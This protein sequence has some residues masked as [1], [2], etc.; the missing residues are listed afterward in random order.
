M[1]AQLEILLLDP[2]AAK[3]LDAAG[4]EE[5]EPAA[6]QKASNVVPIGKGK[7]RARRQPRLPENIPV[8]SQQPRSS[9]TRSSSI[10]NSSAKL[11]S[12]PAS[13]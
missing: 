3:K 8:S 13:A 12:R 5:D 10:R 2:E 9:L 6:E 4:T 1:P 11:V 7:D